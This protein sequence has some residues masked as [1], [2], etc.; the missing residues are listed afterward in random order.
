MY[1]INYQDP[2]STTTTKVYIDKQSLAY[3]KFEIERQRKRD[4]AGFKQSAT[5]E[6]LLF[7][8]KDN[9]W[10][11]KHDRLEMVGTVGADNA[12]I[13]LEFVTNKYE[14]DSVE[15]F[16][17]KEQFLMTDVIADQTNDF[18][19]SFFDGYDM[20]LEQTNGLKNQINLAFDANLLDSLKRGKQPNVEEKM[21]E[22]YQIAQ[23]LKIATFL[24]R[25]TSGMGLT[26]APV[27]SNNAPF[28]LALTEILPEKLSFNSTTKAN[29]FP[30]LVNFTLGFKVTRRWHLS[31]QNQSSVRSSTRIKV[32]EV[33]IAYRWVINSAKKPIFIEPHVYYSSLEAGVNFGSFENTVKRFNLDG[34][35][36][37]ANNI[38]TRLLTKTQ[39]LKAGVSV[40][41]F[42]RGLSKLF[43]QIDYLYPLQ[44]KSPY[45]QLQEA[46][47]WGYIWGNNRRTHLS[48]NDTRVEIPSTQTSQL[49]A[50]KSPWW[51]GIMWRRAI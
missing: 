34:V 19:D 13:L 44:T 35:K 39:G 17:Y 4:I 42:S 6:Q 5:K 33:G 25:L 16:A 15:Q 38:N 29:N 20:G 47:F 41:T 9:T 11:L 31:Y 51:V 30:L 18:S 45:I 49:P 27:A 14:E 46:S 1:I 21:E 3:I 43:V 48:I 22:G 23:K 37:N 50:L 12:K 24:I 7:E 28:S 2:D 10:F 32:R 26:F 40:S 8:N 36:F